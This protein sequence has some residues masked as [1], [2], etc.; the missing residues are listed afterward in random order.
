MMLQRLL[1]RLPWASPPW[2]RLRRWALYRP[3]RRYMRG[4]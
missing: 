2:N 1:A 4:R 3:E